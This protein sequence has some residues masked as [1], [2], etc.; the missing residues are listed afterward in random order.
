MLRIGFDIDDTVVDLCSVL[1]QY[2]EKY[3]TEDL[4]REIKK[5]PLGEIK[6]RKYLN[7]IYGWN[8]LEKHA[9]FDKYYKMVLENCEFLPY[10][11]EILQK[12]IQDGHELYFVSARLSNILNCN[13][14]EITEKMF[15]ENDIRYKELVINEP[16]KLSACQRYHL[17]IFIDDCYETCLH[18]KENNYEAFLIT[19]ILNQNIVDE[20]IKRVHDYEELYDIISCK[21]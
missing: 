17:D 19:S 11:K 20:K 13:T 8:D 6:S 7:E 21:G 14:H 9:F 1:M 15:F 10:A 16:D 2:A 5:N 12:L 3:N 18:L 4:K